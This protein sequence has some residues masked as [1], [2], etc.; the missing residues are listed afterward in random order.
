MAKAKLALGVAAGLFAG[1]HLLFGN[2]ENAKRNMKKLQGFAIKMKGEVVEKLEKAKQISEPI[3]N[4]IVDDVSK[5]YKKIEKGQLNEVIADLKKQGKKILKD[6]KAE[7]GE[8]QV[9]AS[10]KVNEVANK[11]ASKTASKNSK[12]VAVKAPA[13]KAESKGLKTT[14]KTIVNKKAKSKTVVKT[15]KGKVGNMNVNAAESVTVANPLP[16]VTETVVE[17][18]VVANTDTQ[19]S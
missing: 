15:A 11:V 3:Y 14:T 6:V 12:K 13:K 17:Q 1:A 4:Q 10:K 9:V 18:V 2:S 16:G 19:N 8:L 7:V 5:K